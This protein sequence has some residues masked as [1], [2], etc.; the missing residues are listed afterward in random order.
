MSLPI[1]NPY[2]KDRFAV[3][4]PDYDPAAAA[5]RLKYLP[6]LAAQAHFT[7][8]ELAQ[9]DSAIAKLAAD[10][11]LL[12][13][14]DLMIRD[15]SNGSGAKLMGEED[16]FAPDSSDPICPDTL[17]LLVELGCIPGMIRMYRERG[18]YDD[19]FGQALLDIR[20]WMDFAVQNYGT[21]GVRMGHAWICAQFDGRVI[22]LGRLQCNAPGEFFREYKV[23]RN[24]LTGEFCTLLNVEM[25]FNAEGLYALDDDPVA[26]RT[27]T[28]V[29][30]E[31][32][33][34]GWYAGNDARVAGQTVTLKKTE[35]EL[36]L[37]QEDVICNLH[38][39]ADGPL[40]EADCR[41]SLARMKAFYQK[42]FH[43]TP[44]AFI[45]ESWLLDPV[46]ASLLPE[47]SNILA[48][49]QLGHLLP[50]PG[51][52]EMVNRVFGVKAL[53]DGLNAV[54]HKTRMQKIFAAYAE[55]GGKFRNGAF[56]IPA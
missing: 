29:E 40:L 17:N 18:W 25:P 43:V 22:R 48:F 46:F 54:P 52:S 26:F 51:K 9:L 19:A 55:N 38:I 12:H 35:W 41:D 36:F 28:P 53:K 15:I 49:Q 20:I 8:S 44:K 3:P 10:E 37:S 6:A 21:F 11:E 56:F 33:V 14:H 42:Y 45:C 32:T 5:E 39:P 27:A 24:R 4:D 7:A 2:W 34:T 47:T 1:L 23:Y 16:T 31:N 13:L 50:F 30:T